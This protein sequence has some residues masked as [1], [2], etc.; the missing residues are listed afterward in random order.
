[1]GTNDKTPERTQLALP[2]GTLERI[3]AAAESEGLSQ[4]AWIRRLIFLGLLENERLRGI[5]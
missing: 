1:M 2:E 5:A 4:S 3:K